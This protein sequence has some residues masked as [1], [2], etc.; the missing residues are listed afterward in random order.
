MFDT[1]VCTCDTV[2]W[3]FDTVVATF[4]TAASVRR[5]P[6]NYV[7][8]HESTSDRVGVSHHGVTDAR[9]K[10]SVNVFDILRDRI[11]AEMLTHDML[12]C[13]L[14]PFLLQCGNGPAASSAV[15]FTIYMMG[16]PHFAKA[17]MRSAISGGTVE[18]GDVYGR[19]MATT[20]SISSLK[21]IKLLSF[22]HLV[23]T[24]HEHGKVKTS[25]HRHHSPGRL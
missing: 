3:T 18:S 24:T 15:R 13:L 6:S 21:F 11:C 14:D 7:S 2:V 23:C 9:G 20:R 17:C 4:D 10:F 19:M 1:V 25:L 8:C 5:P 22:P 16:G 12:R